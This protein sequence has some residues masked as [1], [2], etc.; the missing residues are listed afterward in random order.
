MTKWIRSLSLPVLLGLVFCNPVLAAKPPGLVIDLA[1]AASSR[2]P[3]VRMSVNRLNQRAEPFS[4][5]IGTY[6]L[7]YDVDS[8]IIRAV[9]AVESCYQEKAKSPKGAMGL[10]QL[11]PA[12]AERF[13]IEDAWNSNQNIHGGTQYLKWLMKRYGNDLIKVFAAYNAGE[14]RV[15]RYGGIPPFR[16][17]QAYVRNVLM[18][19]YK[20]KFHEEEVLSV[21]EQLPK[22][23]VELTLTDELMRGVA[24]KLNVATSGGR[25][26]GKVNGNAA[27]PVG[28]PAVRRPPAAAKV[29]TRPAQ[30]V[31]RQQAQ[32]PV[33][34]PQPARAPLPHEVDIYIPP[35][36]SRPIPQPPAPVARNSNA[37]AVQVRQAAAPQ[38]ASAAVRQAASR[39]AVNPQLR[40]QHAFSRAVDA[41]PAMAAGAA[42]GGRVTA[43]FKPGRGGLAANRAMA[44]Q[45]YK[46]P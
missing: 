43:T 19:F 24:G 38:A 25:N 18:V 31:P 5:S 42:A 29:A 11:I 33:R 3:C 7:I 37:N 4:D 15:D 22:G 6:A 27:P 39:P 20:I 17:T 41:A 23:R 8:A 44:P 16:E 45:L 46:Q 9:I 30:P 26:T 35:P 21:L 1:D 12:T 32:T 36:N 28:T 40:L 2:H 14:G 13:G 34:R 10:M